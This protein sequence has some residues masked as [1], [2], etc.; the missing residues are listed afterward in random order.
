MGTF[1]N[2][3]EADAIIKFQHRKELSEWM[4]SDQPAKK[5]ND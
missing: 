5:A 2:S 1:L 4:N 3:S